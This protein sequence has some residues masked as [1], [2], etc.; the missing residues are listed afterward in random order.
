M[1]NLGKAEAL[2]VAWSLGWRIAAGIILGYY[3]D[4]Y[5]GTVPWLTLGFSLTALVTGVRSMLALLAADRPADDSGS[6][7]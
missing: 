6:R 4:I 5:L 1:A 2:A 3:A 7:R